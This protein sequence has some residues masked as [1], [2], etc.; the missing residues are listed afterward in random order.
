[1]PVHLYNTRTRR[2]EEFVPLDPP[3]VR[4]YHCGP[5]VYSSPHI[6][7]FRSF[8]MADLLGRHLRHRGY[9]VTQVMNI[10]DVGHLTEDDIE[11]GEDK[12]LAA[13]RKERLDP[14]EVARKYEAEFMRAA[15]TLRFR[16]EDYSFP[17][18]TEH[19]PEMQ[20]LIADL[21]EHGHAYRVGDGDVYFSIAT[22]PAFGA[23]SGK[24]LEDLESG[25]R[26]AVVE[27]KQD[28]RDFA[29]WKTD[30]KHLMQWDAPW[31]RGFPGWHIECSAMSRKFLGD[32]FDVH[33]GGED[34][35]VPHH[36]C[37]VAQS[38]AFTGKQP[39]VRYWLHCR[40][41]LVDDRKMAKREGNFFTI[42]DL[43]DRGYDGTT[44]R[45]AL[46]QVHYRKPMNFTLAGLEDCRAQLE[47]VREC[48]ARLLRIREGLEPAGGDDVAAACARRRDEFGAGL[49]DD[50][51][52]AVSLAALQGLVG[53]LNRCRPTAA[54]AA[55][56]LA[57]FRDLDDWCGCVGVEPVV[58]REDSGVVWGGPPDDARRDGICAK[59]AERQAAREARDWARADVLRDEIAAAGFK[60]V[61]TPQGPRVEP[62]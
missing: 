46:M 35:L 61:D 11:A 37:E 59:A 32:Q 1:M 50:L 21:L 42:Q 16:V 49:D 34:N 18:A 7:N 47:R 3:R 24:V 14:F 38:E 45:L 51:N 29:L 56:A 53:D 41:L 39:F 54:G 60:V 19:I 15:R 27:D 62:L 52:L 25:A 10:T 57:L 43:L 44:I 28:P 48:R 9:D 36:E 55:E 2:I 22:F 30:A 26:V 8:L 20:E 12:M 13:A 23:L 4:M 5:T 58:G 17:R 40:H 6:G 33:T 31:G